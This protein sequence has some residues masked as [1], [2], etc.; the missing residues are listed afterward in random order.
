MLYFR[1]IAKAFPLNVTNFDACA[2]I[3]GA[4]TDD[5]P[6]HVI[7]LYPTKTTMGGKIVPC[8]R[9]RP[10]DQRKKLA[11][12]QSPDGEINDEIPF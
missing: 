10:L 8:V 7:V 12:E 6:G 3:C 4:D 9:I 5:W 11:D 1:E 2:A